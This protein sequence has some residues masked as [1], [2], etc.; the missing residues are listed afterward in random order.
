M[1]PKAQR[2][3]LARVR[4]RYVGAGRRAKG[5]L[6]D[7]A[8]AMTG[9]HRKSLMR[10]WRVGPRPPRRRRAGRPTRY[11]PA[12]VRAL[13][14]HPP[15]RPGGRRRRAGVRAQVHVGRDRLGAGGPAERREVGRHRERQAAYHRRRYG[16]GE[17]ADCRQAPSH[18]SRDGDGARAAARPAAAR[19]APAAGDRAESLSRRL[20]RWGLLQWQSSR[21]QRLLETQE[22]YRRGRAGTAHPRP[23][24]GADVGV[25]GSTRTRTRYV[26]LP[27]GTLGE[28]W[29][30]TV[31]RTRGR[32]QEAVALTSWISPGARIPRQSRCWPQEDSAG[33]HQCRG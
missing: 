5:R 19:L 22:T 8:V 23:A 12:V 25:C 4:E 32:R 13:G 27:R 7:E 31:G 14:A 33:D 9:R 28:T 11:G 17:R 29:P 30:M 2:E 18:R 20:R 24:A 15:G 6:L 3:Y 26:V 16:E 1:G 21:L 10:A